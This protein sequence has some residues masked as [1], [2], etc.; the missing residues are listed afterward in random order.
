MSGDNKTLT[1]L[2][3]QRGDW[4]VQWD[5]SLDKYTITHPKMEGDPVNAVHDNSRGIR[6]LVWCF[7][8]IKEAKQRDG[9][10]RKPNAEDNDNGSK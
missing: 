4:S 6:D 1:V 5:S 3:A 10:L 2:H 7:T 8:T 9:M